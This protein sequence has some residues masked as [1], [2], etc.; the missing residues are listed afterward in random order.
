MV[1]LNVEIGGQGGVRLPK[2]KIVWHLPLVLFSKLSPR[3]I[4]RRKAGTFKCS[5]FFPFLTEE[6]GE[7]GFLLLIPMVAFR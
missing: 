2:Q 1:E 6:L 7:P 5:L 4:A 3:S